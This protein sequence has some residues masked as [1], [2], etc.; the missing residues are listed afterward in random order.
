MRRS[1]FCATAGAAAAAAM[2]WPV[3]A[4]RAADRLEGRAAVPVV[5]VHLK[6]RELVMAIDTGDALSTLSPQAAAALGLTATPI[7]GTSVARLTLGGVEFAGAVLREHT[8]IVADVAHVRED[9]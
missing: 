3:P 1:T 7:P 9:G 4:A 8:A 6:G 5:R 2:P